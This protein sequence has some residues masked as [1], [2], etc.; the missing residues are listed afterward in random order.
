MKSIFQAVEFE[1]V[2]S[3]KFK[4]PLKQSQVIPYLDSDVTFLTTLMKNKL[5]PVLI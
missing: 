5:T 1:S 2:N 3:T 4:I